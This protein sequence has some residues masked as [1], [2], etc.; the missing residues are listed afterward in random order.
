MQLSASFL[1]C[2]QR[3][4][5]TPR[6]AARFADGLLATPTAGVPEV[7]K[8][9]S[10]AKVPHAALALLASNTPGALGL[11]PR[12]KRS[13]VTEA[14]DVPV[15]DSREHHQ[16]LAEATFATMAEDRGSGW[17]RPDL[18]SPESFRAAWDF[19]LSHAEL[20]RLRTVELGRDASKQ[21]LELTRFEETICAFRAENQK[22]RKDIE[23]HKQRCQCV[24][25]LLERVREENRS[26]EI[27]MMV[28]FSP[29]SDGLRKQTSG[30]QK[31][32]KMKHWSKQIRVPS[33]DQV[34]PDVAAAAAASM[35]ALIGAGV[36]PTPPGTTISSRC[37]PRRTPRGTPAT[38]RGGAQSLVDLLPKFKFHTVSLQVISS[39]AAVTGQ[40]LAEDDSSASLFSE[41]PKRPFFSGDTCA[42]ER[43]KV[44]NGGPGCD[45]IDRKTIT[46]FPAPPV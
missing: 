41:Q 16:L 27:K 44:N 13:I 43:I 26:L 20:S 17:Y 38:P 30:S 39:N 36:S 31:F 42:I 24:E 28:G 2:S 34:S 32:A 10:P 8:V 22:L 15:L 25:D 3:E 45:W 37:T 1:C 14:D 35:A 18:D 21:S 5:L 4:A 11:G 19:P 7:D 46:L 9:L 6:D 23:D 29:R 12:S 40:P 33:L